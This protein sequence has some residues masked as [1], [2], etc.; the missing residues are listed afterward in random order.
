MI[1]LLSPAVKDDIRA[2]RLNVRL[3]RFALLCSGALIVVLGIYGVGLYAVQQDRAAAD[4]EILV[5]QQATKNKEYE[6]TVTEA[7][8]YKTNLT[9]A[10]KVLSSGISYSSFVTETA[11]LLPPGT[12][13]ASLS[14]SNL[15][16]PATPANAAA[17]SLTLNARTTSYDG[18]LQLQKSLED[19]DLYEKVSISNVSIV[20]EESRSTNTDKKYPVTLTVKATVSQVKAAR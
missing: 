3:S 5:N 1:N 17:N 14:L 11:R 12:L 6:T 8:A 18:A 2:A 15:G 7:K 19:S 10:D 20:P 13:L 4:K 9:I 16:A